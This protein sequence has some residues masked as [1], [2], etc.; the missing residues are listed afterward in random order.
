M[1]PVVHGKT[2]PEIQSV[3]LLRHEHR[4][5]FDHS[6]EQDRVKNVALQIDTLRSYLREIPGRDCQI[7]FI[8]V[9]PVQDNEVTRFLRVLGGEEV[10]ESTEVKPEVEEAIPDGT[11]DLK[12]MAST[13]LAEDADCIVTDDKSKLAFADDLRAKVS[14]TV[15]DLDSI[16]GS[17]E[18]FT[19]GHEIPWSFKRPIWGCPFGEFYAMTE[20][21]MPLT[22][23][24]DA[25]LKKAN[26]KKLNPE[27]TEYARSIAL[28]RMTNLCYARDKLLFYDQQRRSTKRAE[29]QR[30]SFW[31]EAGYHLN[32]FYI[33][34]WGG[35]DQM[36]WIINEV[37]D[38]GYSLSNRKHW[39]NV[40]P[41]KTPYLDKLKQKS[42]PLYELV[43]SKDFLKWFK[44]LR[45][46]R[47]FAAHNG[48]VMPTTLLK[49]PDQELTEE[50]LEEAVQSD[51][52]FQDMQSW[53]AAGQFPTQM[54]E[55]FKE[56]LR[57]K[58]RVEQ[59][60]VVSD[61]V[62]EIKIDGKPVLITPL[63]NTMW[64]FEN[65]LQFIEK[66]AEECTAHLLQ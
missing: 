8:F 39:S 19:R 66:S 3:S 42:V 52:S 32:H 9:Q 15:E 16:L 46:A 36:C 64:D 53:T 12:I 54:L 58:K 28:P 2:Y 7:K 35:V 14:V 1:P 62:L 57:Y 38:L 25:F 60:S 63:L 4:L 22:N 29:L 33:L 26:E 21:N 23:L 20:P 6:S 48:T 59:Y 45:G 30:Q 10:S 18:V 50:E 34:H 17:C 56:Q 43:T 65:Y 27:I 31:F 41:T 13:A 5:L 49:K 47:H 61:D 40:G 55:W 44:T 24:Y 51:R 11:A 37:F